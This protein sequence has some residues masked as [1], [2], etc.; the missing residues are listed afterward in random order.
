MFLWLRQSCWGPR[1]NALLFRH[2]R[3]YDGLEWTACGSDDSS[4]EDGTVLK[5]DIHNTS[6]S[7]VHAQS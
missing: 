2:L 4:V 5:K 3:C 7:H 1:D 6:Y